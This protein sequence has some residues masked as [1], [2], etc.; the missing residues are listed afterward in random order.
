[1]NAI[2]RLSLL[3]AVVAGVAF[4]QD[5]NLTK[6]NVSGLVTDET[7]APVHRATVHIE[8]ADHQKTFIVKTSTEGTFSYQSLPVVEYRV[9]AESKGQ[10][11]SVLELARAPG[12][13]NVTL[14][15]GK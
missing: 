11:S 5:L 12:L 3:L 7:G 1:M 14:K 8:R 2:T 13:R 10:S 6:T 15:L 9:W 4:G